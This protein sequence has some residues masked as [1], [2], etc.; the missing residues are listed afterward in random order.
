M[1][2]P[3]ISESL[4]ERIKHV[5]DTRFMGSE[6][7]KGKQEPLNVYVVTGMKSSWNFG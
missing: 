3:I 5:A 2:M 4:Y 1:N 6:R 7:V